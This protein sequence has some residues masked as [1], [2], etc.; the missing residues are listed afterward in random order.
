MADQILNSLLKDY[1][2]KKSNAELE[3]E[4]RKISLYEKFPN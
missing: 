4:N 3:A 1:E 2:K